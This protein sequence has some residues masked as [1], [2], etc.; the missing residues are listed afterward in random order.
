MSPSSY[1]EPK[2]HT[3]ETPQIGPRPTTDTHTHP[4][5]LTPSDTTIKRRLNR[6]HNSASADRYS[7]HP[8]AWEHKHS[9]S[10]QN[11]PCRGAHPPNRQHMCTHI[12]H[13]DTQR[14]SEIQRNRQTA[15]ASHV[16]THTSSRQHNTHNPRKRPR[17]RTSRLRHTSSPSYDP[18]NRRFPEHRRCPS[19]G[20]GPC[21][22]DHVPQA[23]P[24]PGVAAKTRQH[25]A[26]P[27]P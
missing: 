11:R 19:Q 3:P 21:L 9:L 26:P 12:L 10:H 1:T 5:T 25:W 13:P 4:D 14:H 18:P 22:R 20:P 24:W 7:T 2:G 6:M 17:A 23:S 8:I 27:P 15:A 16:R